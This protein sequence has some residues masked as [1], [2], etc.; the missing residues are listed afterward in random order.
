LKKRKG[1][2][3]RVVKSIAR[4]VLDKKA[5]GVVLMDLRKITMATDFFIIATGESDTHV[6]AIADHLIEETAKK[7]K[8]K[9]WHVEGY[10]LA[11]WV[12]LD[13][14]DFI[15]HIFQPVPRDYYNLERLWGDAGMEEIHE[16][17]Q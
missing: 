4:L 16:E 8:L 17:V 10:E 15:V 14:V 11:Q 12:L 2:H 9:P 13:Y 5:L 6:R 1:A 3:K 7:R